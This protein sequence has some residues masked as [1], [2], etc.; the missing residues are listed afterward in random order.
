VRRYLFLLAFVAG[1]AS[2]DPWDTT[3][4]VLGATAVTALVLDWGQTRYIAKHPD[5]FYEKNPL[6]PTHPSVGRVNTHFVLAITGTLLIADY[7]SP[8]N[9][10][11][12]LATM[13]VLELNVVGKNKSLGVRVDF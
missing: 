9:R 6:L 10:K 2:A 7:L 1:T 13:T 8:S 4:K 12:F 3:D 11:V 5:Q